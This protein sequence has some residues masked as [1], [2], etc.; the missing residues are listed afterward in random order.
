[1][2]SS[3]CRLETAIRLKKS[4]R[5]AV[6]QKTPIPFSAATVH[7]SRSAAVTAVL[8]I[9]GTA[10][11]SQ[12]IPMHKPHL[13]KTNAMTT[14]PLRS[15]YRQIPVNPAIPHLPPVLPLHLQPVQEAVPLPPLKVPAV[16][17]FPLRPTT[18]NGLW[19][20]CRCTAPVL[21]L[22]ICPDTP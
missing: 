7:P 3:V 22:P 9:S 8:F 1:M 11:N 20:P 15:M 16:P 13:S 2:P 12:A 6:T 18:Q 19:A 5:Q 4:I 21:S 14:V 17:R 10:E